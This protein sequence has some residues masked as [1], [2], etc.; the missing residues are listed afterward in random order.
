MLPADT[1]AAKKTGTKNVT[2][3]TAEVSE[4]LAQEERRTEKLTYL[5]K[6]LP[7]LITDSQSNLASGKKKSEQSKCL[8]IEKLINYGI[9]WQLKMHE[10]DLHVV[11]WIDLENVL[12]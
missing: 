10:L 5:Q 11:T 3:F 4:G 6:P 7:S 9:L 8:S 2:R 1:G 12:S